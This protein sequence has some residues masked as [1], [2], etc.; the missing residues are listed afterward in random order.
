MAMHNDHGK[1]QSNG[2]HIQIFPAWLWERNKCLTCVETWLLLVCNAS[3]ATGTDVQVPMFWCCL[4]ISC[5]FHE[6]PSSQ[7]CLQQM[8]VWK[9]QT[10]QQLVFEDSEWLLGIWKEASFCGCLHP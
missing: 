4:L 1:S 9:D 5:E 2:L 6:F 10:I 3:R 8:S 7:H